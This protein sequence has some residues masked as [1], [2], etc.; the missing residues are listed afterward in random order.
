MLTH[1]IV[2]FCTAALAFLS[3]IAVTVVDLKTDTA[4]ISAKV[5]ANHQMLTPLW[6]DFL[7]THSNDNLAWFDR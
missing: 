1:I 6:Q 4:V 7:R 3:W 5:A 2:I